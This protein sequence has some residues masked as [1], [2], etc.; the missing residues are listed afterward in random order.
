MLTNPNL[1]GATESQDPTVL[2]GFYL[3]SVKAGA[4]LAD[5]NVLVE[6]RQF[7]Q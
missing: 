6:Y 7:L 5:P 2:V 4:L 3:P 1:I